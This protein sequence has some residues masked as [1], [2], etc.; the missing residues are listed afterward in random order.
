MAKIEIE[1]SKLRDIIYHAHFTGREEQAREIDSSS[2]RYTD[3]FMR[4]S[5][6]IKTDLVIPWELLDERLMFAAQEEDGEVKISQVEFI[7]FNEGSWF[8]AKTQVPVIRNAQFIKGVIPSNKPWNQTLVK[9]P[10][11]E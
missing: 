2:A 7:K 8:P 4:E 10:V 11:K 9:R 1:E 5:G 6:L 3:T